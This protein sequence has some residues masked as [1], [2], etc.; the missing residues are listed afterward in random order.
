MKTAAAVTLL[1]GIAVGQATKAAPP[2]RNSSPATATKMS[3]VYR[4]ESHCLTAPEIRSDKDAPISCYCR[5]A[6]ASARYVFFTYFLPGKDDNL[7]GVV[8]S[9]QELVTQKCGEQNYSVIHDATESKDWKWNGPEVVRT[10]PPQDVIERISPEMK[11]GRPV[12]RWVPFTVQL[13]YRDA[14]GRV[15]RTENNSSRESEPVFK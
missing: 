3:D 6:I 9:L 13:V 2:D 12:A 14:Q 4:D 15:T 11:D 10:Y 8:L 1:A 5:D 7:S